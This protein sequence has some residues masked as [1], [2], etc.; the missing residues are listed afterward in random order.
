M[1]NDFYMRIGDAL[2]ESD[3]NLKQEKVHQLYADYCQNNLIRNNTADLQEVLTP[4]RPTKPELVPPKEV[5]RRRLGTEKGVIAMIHAVLHI[6]FN[7]INLALDA[8]YR[9]RSMPEQYYRDWLQVAHEEAQHF[10]LL[11]S[12]LANRKIPAQYGDLTAHNGLWDAAKATAHDPLIRMAM[13]PRVL[14]ARGLDVSPKLIEK[15]KM[16][17]ENDLVEALNIILLEEEGHVVIG[18]RWFQYLCQQ[19]Q[20]NPEETFF[21]LLASYGYAPLSGPFNLTARARSGF[22]KTELEK[23]VK[24]APYFKENHL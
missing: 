5:P 9:F 17:H 11:A 20:M 16:M 1:I 14:E 3:V 12:C 15:L 10:S 13:V 19:R 23:L 18:N 8:A 24:D 6:E 21:S 7:A 2:Y 4:G 22:S